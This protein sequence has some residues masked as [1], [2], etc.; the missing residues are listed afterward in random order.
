MSFD[1][2]T[3]FASAKIAYD[4]A[5]GISA[6]NTDVERNQ[7]VSKVLEV[8]LSV[9][10]DALLMQKEHSLLLHEKDD[11]IKKISEFEDWAETER[12]HETAFVIPDIRVYIR[13]GIDDAARQ[14]EH[15]YCTNCW[16]DRK[17]SILHLLNKNDYVVIY[18]CPKCKNQFRHDIP[19]KPLGR[20]VI[21][22]GV[23]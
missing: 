10:Q 7:A 13:K 1:P 14:T 2:A 8:L 5:K 3:I 6:L 16:T 21:H 22:P 15:W 17:Q 12:N 9:Q 20:S 19:H 4:L 11:L 23:L 18:F